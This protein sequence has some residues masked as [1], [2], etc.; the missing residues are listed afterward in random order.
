MRCC[1]VAGVFTLRD[2]Y[3]NVGTYETTPD[4]LPVLGLQ[5]IELIAKRQLV[6]QLTTNTTYDS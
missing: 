6:C 3:L 4:A 1:H 5:K 2:V